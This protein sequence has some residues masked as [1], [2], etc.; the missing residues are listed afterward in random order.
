MCFKCQKIVFGSSPEPAKK[1]LM[2][3]VFADKLCLKVLGRP[4]WE[5]ST[6]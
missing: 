3:V 6:T 2:G 4:I 5:D 1:I